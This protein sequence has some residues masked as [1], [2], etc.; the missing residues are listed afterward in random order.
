LKIKLF[1][2]IIVILEELVYLID[3]PRFSLLNLLN[4]YIVVKNIF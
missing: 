4:L 2:G 3:I 1:G